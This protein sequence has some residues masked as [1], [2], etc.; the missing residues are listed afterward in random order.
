MEIIKGKKLEGNC[1]LELQKEREQI[2]LVLVEK[3]EKGNLAAETIFA[4][5]VAENILEEKYNEYY[6]QISNYADFFKLSNQVREE[7]ERL[8]KKSN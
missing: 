8:I 3:D 4:A 2:R 6:D 5:E 1:S 7:I